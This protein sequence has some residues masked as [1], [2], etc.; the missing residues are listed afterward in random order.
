MKRGVLALVAA[1]LV[2][3]ALLGGCSRARKAPSTPGRTGGTTS[4]LATRT[5]TA[6]AVDVKV[7]PVRLDASG[8]AFEVIL[9]THSVELGMDMAKVAGLEV[10]GTPWTGASWKG[11]GPGGHHREGTLS[12]SPAGPATGRAVLTIGG[13]PAPVEVSWDLVS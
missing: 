2:G 10:G 13:L 12:F 3:A 9:D 11:A 5:V 1:A 6:G 8:A 7:R 4:R